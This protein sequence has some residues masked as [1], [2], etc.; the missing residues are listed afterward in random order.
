MN[1]I[2]RHHFWQAAGKHSGHIFY[3]GYNEE[4]Q[5][6][7]AKDRLLVYKVSDGW[8]P[9]C[10]FLGKPTP[11]HS[12]PKTNDTA[13][14]QRNLEIMAE[15]ADAVV[16]KRMWMVAGLVSALVATSVATVYARAVP[17]W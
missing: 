1:E 7:V 16:Y 8:A 13:I 11:N 12:F 15:A 6:L 14:F 9:L 3:Q 2:L 4:I 5:R 10:K 17:S